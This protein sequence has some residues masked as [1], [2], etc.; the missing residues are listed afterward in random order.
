MSMLDALIVMVAGMAIVMAELALLAVLIII[1]S[2]V[3]RGLTGKK[4]PEKGS[5]P[6]PQSAPNL[7]APAQPAAAQAVSAGC[8]DLHNVDDRTAA[9]IMAIVSD[10]S[11]IPLNELRFK[12]IKAID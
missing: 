6:A 5:E 3:I 1:M 7:Q 9:M 12:S 2:K 4:E 10:D 11:G 8:L